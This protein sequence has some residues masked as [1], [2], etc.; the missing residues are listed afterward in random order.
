MLH[1]LLVYGPFFKPFNKQCL[2]FVEP[3]FLVVL[4]EEELVVIDLK[5]KETG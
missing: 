5:T 4:C 3:A 2:F 1:C